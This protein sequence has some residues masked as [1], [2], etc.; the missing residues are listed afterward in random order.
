[1]LLLFPVNFRT[2]F[3]NI[4]QICIIFL[5]F[6]KYSSNLHNFSN[7]FQIFFKISYN[8][9]KSFVRFQDQSTIRDRR[10]KFLLHGENYDQDERKIW[11]H[12]FASFDCAIIFNSFPTGLVQWCSTHSRMRKQHFEGVSRIFISIL[13]LAERG[14]YSKLICRSQHRPS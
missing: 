8:R 14:M 3:L 1:M 2:I 13:P 11:Y 10:Y 12:P 7:F 9:R 5:I 6:F 4:L